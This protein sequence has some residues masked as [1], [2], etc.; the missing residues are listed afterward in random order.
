M[1]GHTV[2]NEVAIYEETRSLS[3]IEKIHLVEM[4][5]SDLDKPDQSITEIWAQESKKRWDAY[6]QGKVVA[7]DHEEVMNKY[8]RR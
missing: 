2:S 1:S 8:L 5:L 6:C 7:R 3:S 4:V